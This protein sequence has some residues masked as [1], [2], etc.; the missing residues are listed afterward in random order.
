MLTSA[1]KIGQQLSP[2]K[3]LLLS[4]GEHFKNKLW[5]TFTY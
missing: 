3:A 2:R 5:S 1:E 4:A